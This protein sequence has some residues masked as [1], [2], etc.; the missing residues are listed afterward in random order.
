MAASM[1]TPETLRPLAKA[2][3]VA[4]VEHRRHD[5][6]DVAAVEG[7]RRKPRQIA[8]RGDHADADHGDESAKRLQGGKPHA[9]EKPGL[10]ARQARG[11]RPG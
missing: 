1:L 8:L 3:R 5:H 2:D 6:H 10:Q 11:W 7:E 9:E 4:G